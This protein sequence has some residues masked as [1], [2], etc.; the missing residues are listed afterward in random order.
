V[1]YI[2][3]PPSFNEGQPQNYLEW[4]GERKPSLLDSVILTCLQFLQHSGVRRIGKLIAKMRYTDDP[5]NRRKTYFY[6]PQK[7]IMEFLLQNMHDMQRIGSVWSALNRKSMLNEVCHYLEN[8][9]RDPEFPL[10]KPD[11]ALFAFDN[12][13]YAIDVVMDGNEELF[14]DG[15]FY[16]WDHPAIAR[17]EKTNICAANY[18]P[19]KVKDAWLTSEARINPSII[20]TPMLTMMLQHQRYDKLAQSNFFALAIGRMLYPVNRHEEFQIAIFLYGA[21]KCGKSTLIKFI[22]GFYPSSDTYVFSSN[23]QAQF[24]LANA[25]DANMVFVCDVK[26]NFALPQS[27]FQSM[28][29][30]EAME[31]ARK[32]VQETIQKEWTAPIMLAGNEWFN[33]N[34]TAD[35]VNRRLLTF[36]FPNPVE[37]Q[38]NNLSGKL[39]SERAAALIKGIYEYR[40]LA[41]D[42]SDKE[43]DIWDDDYLSPILHRERNRIRSE[44]NPLMA[45]MLSG[46]LM[47]PELLGNASCTTGECGEQQD[48]RPYVYRKDSEDQYIYMPN[49]EF[50]KAYKE[51]LIEGGYDVRTSKKI[52]PYQ[53]AHIFRSFGL[54][55]KPPSELWSE[56]Y[57]R[58]QA[59]EQ[60]Q[61]LPEDRMT[62]P[63]MKLTYPRV[64]LGNGNGNNRGR[65]ITDKFI[66]G[67]DRACFDQL[68]T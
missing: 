11:P 51:F 50:Q 15:M 4:L 19:G 27:Q 14:D 57:R 64:P 22:R 10:C 53:E 24:S 65:V 67:A 35:C 46:H 61:S 66:F 37:K 43:K 12:G 7:T 23:T 62:G 45:F 39:N 63:M 21:G 28:V 42:L 36:P 30:G 5:I 9:F 20:P 1:I 58:I 6:E 2:P 47:G 59:N 60:I 8:S 41:R 26:K 54:T 33:Y 16:K 32:H 40:K 29:C 52:D 55:R 44:S 31:F 68:S 25:V 13:L 18:I 49:A 48:A 34:D 3:I 56:D 17:L 38:I